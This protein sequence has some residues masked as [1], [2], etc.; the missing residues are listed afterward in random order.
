MSLNIN[1]AKSIKFVTLNTNS[2]CLK[3]LS[4][5]PFF[6]IYLF[7]EFFFIYMDI[8]VKYLIY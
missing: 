3:I 1:I 4:L 5:L 6:L 8:G 2:Y 7:V